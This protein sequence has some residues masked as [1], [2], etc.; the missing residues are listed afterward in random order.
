MYII[1]FPTAG[2]QV[3]SLSKPLLSRQIQGC[4]TETSPTKHGR[5]YWSARVI[6]SLEYGEVSAQL[7]HEENRIVCW[8]F[9]NLN[10]VEGVAQIVLQLLQHRSTQ[11][12]LP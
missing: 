4:L 1:H 10:I 3:T 11:N 9:S 12:R 2:K 5:H 7:I 8:W 6:I